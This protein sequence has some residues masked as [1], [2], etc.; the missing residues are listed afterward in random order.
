MIIY[1]PIIDYVSWKKLSFSKKK[2][3]ECLIG[4]SL[5]NDF[6]ECENIYFNIKRD[7]TNYN[8]ILIK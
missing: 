7:T 4:C 6:C 8:M 3:K 5:K 1:T 2:S